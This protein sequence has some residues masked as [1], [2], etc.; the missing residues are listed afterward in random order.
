LNTNMQN[1]IEN[2]QPEFPLTAKIHDLLNKSKYEEAREVINTRLKDFSVETALTIEQL[3][4][5]GCLVDL[6]CESNNEQDL[7]NA[8]SFLEA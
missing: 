8:I 5:Y 3:E 2:T 6:G 7:T 1:N 4:Y